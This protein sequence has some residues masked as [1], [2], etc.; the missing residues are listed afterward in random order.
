MQSP[1]LAQIY[2]AL[3]EEGLRKARWQERMR[4]WNQ[5]AQLLWTALY[6]LLWIPTGW[7]AALRDALGGNGA[8]PALLFVLVFMLL[9]IPF[10]LP[11]AWF[12]DYR[13]ENLLG[14]N[15]QSLGGWLLDQLKQGLIGALLLGLFFWAVYL[16]F[17]AWPGGWWLALL[18]VVALLMVGIYLVQPLLIRAQFKAEPLEDEELVARLKA[19]FE[20]AGFPFGGVGVLRAGEKTA[21]GNAMLSPK[22]GRLEVL[23]FD[24]LLDEVG[25]E[26]LEFV[27]AHELGHRAHKDWPW[28]LGLFGLLFALGIALAHAVLVWTAGRWGLAG[29][30]DVATL[31]LL[32][33]TLTIWLMLTQVISN[34]FMRTREYAADR[35]ALELVPNLPAFESTFVALAK[36]NLADPEPPEWVELWLHNHPSIARRLEAAR[37]VVRSS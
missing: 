19:L 1:A 17:R 29:P 2:E 35:Y 23:V 26:G 8:W 15:R 33:L 34:A 30:G 37:R 18:A 28:M 10:N 24:T 27:V 21:R 32:Y 11:L 6:A 14:T 4:V 5:V 12:F 7:A 25:P 9:M 20:R 31:P 22:G 3:G 36:Q 16:V 13:V